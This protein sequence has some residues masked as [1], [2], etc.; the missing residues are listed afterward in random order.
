[1]QSEFTDHRQR[2]KSADQKHYPLPLPT[3]AQRRFLQRVLNRAS[4]KEGWTVP[5]NRERASADALFRMGYMEQR[6]TNYSV[7]YSFPYTT[8]AYNFT[9]EFRLQQRPHIVEWV[10]TLLEGVPA[11]MEQ[12][13][14]GGE[15]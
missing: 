12:A 5:E 14:S 2:R 15:R 11:H 8:P 4:V 9:H 1:M 10:N 7:R 3:R 13:R 6:L